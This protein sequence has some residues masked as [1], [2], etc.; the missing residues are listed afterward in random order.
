MADPIEYNTSSGAL[1]R[2]AE[3]AVFFKGWKSDVDNRNHDLLCAEMSRLAYASPE[4]VRGAVGRIGFTTVE[5]IGGESL[6]ERFGAS[7]TQGFVAHNPGLRLTVL[8]FR[9]TE[10]D[11]VED[12]LSDGRTLDQKEWPKSKGCLVHCGF[13]GCW[14]PVSER[15]AHL[16]TDRQGTLLITGHSLGAAVATLAAIDAKPDALI[17]FGSP[18]VGN[19]KLGALLAGTTIRRYVNC[20]DLIARIPPEQFDQEHVETLLTEIAG[21]Q[22]LAHVGAFFVATA[23]HILHREPHFTHVCPARYVDRNGTL[24]PDITDADRHRDQ[25]AAR[26]AYRTTLT[27]APLRDLADHAPINYVSAF[28]G[29][30]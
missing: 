5:P 20:C 25:E 4:T 22:G 10:S 23:L 13:A 27:S 17:T 21:L 16:L 14:S 30:L 29:R 3:N 11:K 1:L 12:L 19:D 8:A 2:P 26:Q 28:A 24:K 15:V 9:G 6:K 18:L 7:G